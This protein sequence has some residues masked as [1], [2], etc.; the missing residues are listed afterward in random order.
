MP[1]RPR[2]PRSVPLDLQATV[3]DYMVPFVTILQRRHPTF[4]MFDDLPRKY[5]WAIPLLEYS[6]A[7]ALLAA[8]ERKVIG[9]LEKLEEVRRQKALPPPRRSAED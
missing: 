8:L 2:D 1:S 4:S 3:P 6:S 7:D 5:H 9:A